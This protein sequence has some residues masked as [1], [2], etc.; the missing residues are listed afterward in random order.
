MSRVRPLSIVVADDHTVV[1]QGLVALI[2]GEPDMRVVGEADNGQQAIAMAKQLQ[3]TLTVLDMRMPGLGGAAAIAQLRACCPAVAVLVLSMSEETSYVRAALSAGASGYVAKR[4]GAD[5]LLRGLR[6]VAS[7]ERFIDPEL[8]QPPITTPP[9]SPLSQR[10]TEV[11]QLIAD[12]HTGPTIAERLGV[13]KSSVDT[14]RVRIFN[15]LGV[16]NRAELIE[17]LRQHLAAPGRQ[18]T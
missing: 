13:S 12:G 15:K 9:A 3:P 11:A 14:Y 18:E 16:Q 6:A 4:S 2:D 17:H 1:R 10:E 5:T 7:G 8:S